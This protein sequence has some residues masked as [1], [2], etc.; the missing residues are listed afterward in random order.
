[1]AVCGQKLH[2]HEN[3]KI[4]AENFICANRQRL[5]KIYNKFDEM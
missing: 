1:M 2:L 4:L 5:L 3:Q